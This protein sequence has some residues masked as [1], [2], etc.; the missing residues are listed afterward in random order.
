MIGK[1]FGSY[2]IESKIGEGGMGVV[3]R[4][5][6][7]D[8]DRPV[9]IKMVLD[10]AAKEGSQGEEVVARFLREAKAAS[11]LQHPAIVHIYKFGVEQNTRYLVMEF[12]E[13]KTLRA[14]IARRPMP[15]ERIC[16]IGG[17]V[18]DG[19]SLAHE[20]GVIHRDLKAENIMVTPRGQAKILD[21][22]LAKVA[23]PILPADETTMDEGYKTQLGTV[24]GT[25]SSMSP[26]QAMGR[27]VD[28]K[29]D[30]FSLG[31][32][33]YEMAT[34]L[35]PFLGPTAQA[36]LARILHHQ[37]ELVSL[38]NPAVPP[39]LERLIHLCLRKDPKQRP[40]AQEITNTCRRLAATVSN[41]AATE[42]NLT[43]QPARPALVPS[44]TPPPSSLPAGVIRP[45]SGSQRTNTP[46]PQPPVSP[47]T[48][49]QLTWRYYSVKT[50]RILFALAT[51]TV[52]L[53]FF[54]YMLVAAEIVRAEIVEGTAAWSYVKAIVVPALDLA[55]RVFTF[56]P[57]V[58]GWNLMLLALGL[59]LLVVRHLLML[60]IERLEFSAKAKLVR[61][62]SALPQGATVPVSDRGVNSRLSLLREYSEG[63]QQRSSRGQRM[64]VLSMD[65]V[66]WARMSQSEDALVVEH[67]FA[68]YKKFVDR[69]LRSFQGQRTSF[70][71]DGTLCVFENTGDA[72][73][74]AQAILKELP[75]FND[76]VHRLKAPFHVRCGINSGDLALPDGKA[77]DELK[78]D[79]IDLAVDV[80]KSAPPDALW[81]PGETLAEASDNS[82]FASVTGQKVDGRSVYEWRALVSSPSVGRPGSARSAG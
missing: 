81:L 72:I 35:N 28:S 18:A 48:L 22:G 20:M 57:V 31:V 66:G 61:A 65:I 52:P 62:R 25:V 1:Q 11:R 79:V 54:V 76:G 3:Y 24:L 74:A 13:G 71:P 2:K 27:E 78:S 63:Q 49:K 6:D 69:L 23:D 17:Q 10:S 70:A 33:L 44:A 40:S 59:V 7:T 39:E 68:E 36:T 37:P 55:G 38:V 58:G 4:A 8:L 60:P 67:A 43:P 82:G 29:A 30:I 45:S 5:T 19:L 32:V 42:T 50:F 47:A 51:I 26:E 9:A 21:F 80:Q 77:L 75:W 73:A 46:L 16:E 34:G 15:V 64:A 41:W 14:I 53:G 56:R 12:V